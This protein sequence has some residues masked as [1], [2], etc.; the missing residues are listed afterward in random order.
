MQHARTRKL[1]RIAMSLGSLSVIAGGLTMYFGPDGLGDGMMIAG[2][3]L[4]IGGVAALASTP[5]GEDEGD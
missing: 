4:L 1:S 2:F 3:A 5:V